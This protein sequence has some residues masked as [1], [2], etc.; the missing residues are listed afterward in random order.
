[1]SDVD[2]KTILLVED[3]AIIALH[4][5]RQLEKAGYRVLHALSGEQSI[6]L[7]NGN[8]G[9]INLILMDIDLGSAMDGTQAAKQILTTHEIPILFLSSHM[10]PEIVRKTEEIT[11]YGYVVKSSVF[12]VLDASIKMAFKLFMAARQLDL[13]SMEIEASNEKLRT[14]IE[15]LENTNRRLTLSEDLFS[16]VFYASPDY[17]SISTVKDGKYI[18]VND[19]LTKM[20]GYSKEEVLGHSSLR[21]IWRNKEDRDGFVEKLRMTGE[22][23]DYETTFHRKN[24]ELF[25]GNV[26]ARIV[27]INGEECL[28]A[29]IKDITERKRK[30]DELTLKSNL[31]DNVGDFVKVFDLDGN[32]MYVN[33]AVCHNTGYS[34]D[35]LIGRNVRF[36]NA[37]ADDSFIRKLIEEIIGSGSKRFESVHV[38]KDGSSFPVDVY[39]VLEPVDRKLILAVDRDISERK[40][41]KKDLLESQKKYQLLFDSASDAILINDNENRILEVNRKVVERLGYSRKELLS[42][43][44]DQIDPTLEKRLTEKRI[45]QIHGNGSLSFRTVQR[46]KNGS[47]IPVEIN[48]M[49]I[50]WEHKPAIMSL[51]RDIS[52]QVKAERA[53]DETYA[54]MKSTLDSQKN[55]YIV[56]IDKDFNCLYCNQAYHDIKARNFGL[57]IGIGTNLLANLQKDGFLQKTLSY[58]KKALQGE[59]VRVLGNFTDMGLYVDEVFNPIFSGS[60]EVI[61]ATSLS[62]NVS[63]R[64]SQD[65]Q[66][67][68]L[69]RNY[70]DLLNSIGEGFCYT[71]DK[72]HFLMANPSAERILKVESKGLVGK[73]IYDFLDEEGVEIVEREAEKRRRGEFTDYI[74]PIVCSDGQRKWIHVSVSP[75]NKLGDQ[76]EGFSLVFR[77]ITEDLQASQNLIQLVKNKETLMKELEHRVKNSLSIVSSLL[78]ITMK[79]VTDSKAISALM[80]T[81]SRIRSMSAIYEYLYLTGSVETIDFGN[82]VEGLA[83]SIFSTF[84]A[85]AT[86]I[87]LVFEVQHVE[88]DTK[89]AISLGLIINELLTNSIK[90]AFPGDR[91]GI[92]KIVFKSDD[93]IIRLAVSDDG[94]GIPEDVI[95][96]TANTMGM[97]LIRLLSEQ[98]DASLKVDSSNGTSIS[99]SFSL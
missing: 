43:T 60:G 39:C 57:D 71:G 68:I 10:E 40:T 6:E 86:S 82:Y 2:G 29:I 7:V 15:T 51:Y 66:L 69:Q 45:E 47:I 87:R 75:R 1:M 65:E 76:Y 48:A 28:I 53:N 90:Y 14:T 72:G 77:D 5:T 50:T 46:C 89:R 84:S 54:M 94:I 19:G 35:E 67:K 61:G 8:P 17:M 30:E 81:E 92:I 70:L 62:M 58:Y 85:H 38:R 42:M 31:L 20:T 78:N 96:S 34:R 21:Y 80:D 91:E 12:T 73:T 59:S 16:K 79:E 3:E 55:I 52:D 44:I 4:E 83:N 63:E 88:I 99:V 22:V 11:N 95:M 64:K 33:D 18:D 25:I 93:G 26:S 24:G 41:I 49:A 37:N 23:L 27:V 97:T 56:S 36:L 98:I 32:L 9:G 13:N 74:S